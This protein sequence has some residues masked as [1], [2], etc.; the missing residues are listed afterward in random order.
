[1]IQRRKRNSSKVNL[2]ISI[3]VHSIL[4]LVVFVFAAREGILGKKLKEITVTMVPKAK[5]PEAPKAKP[6]PPKVEVPKVANRPKPAA[7]PAKVETA[8]APPPADS[9]PSIAPAA[10]QVPSF[11]FSDGAHD[12]RTAS[13]PTEVYKGLVEMALRSRWHRPDNLKDDTFAAMVQVS[14]DS[15]GN[16]TGYQLVSGSGNQRWDDSVKAALAATRTISSPPPKG[17][18]GTFTV[19]FDV[20]AEEVADSAIQLSSR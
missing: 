11:Q 13:S 7:A 14:I 6:A 10:V 15:E 2:T 1:M 17:F 12:V 5:K 3:I 20:A 9:T 4:V 16:L 18:P 8:S 19:R